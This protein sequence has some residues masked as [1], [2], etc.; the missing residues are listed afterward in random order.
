MGGMIL[1]VHVRKRTDCG[2]ERQDAKEPRESICS[3][4]S[5]ST[6]SVIS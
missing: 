5:R 2:F 6:R 1:V 4:Y 3:G